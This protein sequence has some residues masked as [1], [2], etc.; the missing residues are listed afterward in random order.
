PS[1]AG[2]ET[3]PATTA[4]TPAPPPATG[5][6]PTTTSPSSPAAPPRASTPPAPTGPRAS[7]PAAR[8]PAE[9]DQGLLSE[10]EEA[11]KAWVKALGAGDDKAVRDFCLD[12]DDLEEIAGPG[13]REILTTSLLPENLRVVEALMTAADGK[14][15][16]LGAFTPGK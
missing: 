12:E 15:V 13:I 1:P 8:R 5:A 16:V 14:E 3:P 11:V 7:A 6:P 9:D 10:A 2:K 4:P